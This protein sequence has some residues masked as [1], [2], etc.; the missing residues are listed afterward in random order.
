[1][2]DNEKNNQHVRVTVTCLAII[3]CL[4]SVNRLCVNHSPLTR[5]SL[6]H[7]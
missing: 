2:W 4:F 1:M 3:N 6:T 5:H 7:F